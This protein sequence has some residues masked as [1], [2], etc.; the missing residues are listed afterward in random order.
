MYTVLD[1][2][3][4]GQAQ[5]LIMFMLKDWFLFDDLIT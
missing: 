2:V 5:E 3:E 1:G 4:L